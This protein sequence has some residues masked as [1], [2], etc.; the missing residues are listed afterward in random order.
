M[1]SKSNQVPEPEAEST[2]AL[3][4]E[5]VEEELLSSQAVMKHKKSK[6]KTK[7]KTAKTKPNASE[8]QFIVPGG[9]IVVK[10]RK[11]KSRRPKFKKT[12]MEASSTFDK[13][14]VLDFD[15]DDGEII[16]S[17]AENVV[18]NNENFENVSSD[19]GADWSS[20][21]EGEVV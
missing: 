7:H 10:K 4:L 20:E 19:N 14:E 21:E 13:T 15:V 17:E 18:I 16:D 8:N 6:K 3:A 11:K 1:P 5:I 2:S 9:D 12:F